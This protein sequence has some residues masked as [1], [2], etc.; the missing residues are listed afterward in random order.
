MDSLAGLEF[1]FC[2]FPLKSWEY[3]YPA[4][5]NPQGPFFSTIKG[6]LDVKESKISVLW[7]GKGITSP[8]L[9]VPPFTPCTAWGWWVKLACLSVHL[10]IYASAV[11]LCSWQPLFQ[12]MDKHTCHTRASRS[13]ESFAVTSKVAP[14][15][16]CMSNMQ[17]VRWRLRNGKLQLFLEKGRS[18]LH[19]AFHCSWFYYFASRFVWMFVCFVFPK[20]LWC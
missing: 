3:C 17:V 8:I 1:E 5:F 14:S 11:M 15:D 19:Q 18:L 13:A 12:P 20:Q 7:V 4:P 9:A 16:E 2:L 6:Q 10:F